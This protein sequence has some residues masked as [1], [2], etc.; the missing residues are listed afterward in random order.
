M[1][2]AAVV[3]GLVLVV[4][5]GQ[6]YG[7]FAAGAA[8]AR[9]TDA[10]AHH[11]RINLDSTNLDSQHHR[12]RRS[13]P[14][15]VHVNVEF[16]AFDRHFD[17]LLQPT[18]LPFSPR[19]QA[20]LIT[21]HGPE[22]IDFKPSAFY[23]GV[24]RGRSSDESDIRALIVDGVLDGSV[25]VDGET[26]YIEPAHR[27]NVTTHSH[28]VYKMS[29]VAPVPA[30]ACGL[31]D[32]HDH[33]HGQGHGHGHG[34]GAGSMD[35]AA[36]PHEKLV[37]GQKD[38][39]IPTSKYTHE[40]MRVRRAGAGGD[41]LKNTCELALIADH[42]FFA[43]SQGQSSAVTTA[44]A[45]VA[46]LEDVNR[47]YK[48]TDWD[49]VGTGIQLAVAQ[50]TVYDSAVASGNPFP[51]SGS[52][53][54]SAF[55]DQ[56]SAVDW[57]DFCLAHAFTTLDFD[58]G[59]LGLAYVGTICRDSANFGTSS[60]TGQTLRSRNTGITTITNFGSTSPRTQSMLVFAHEL[61]H[62]FGSNHDDSCSSF[63]AS[64]PCDG[65]SCTCSSGT[66]SSP[67]GNFVMFPVSVD[68][69]EASNFVFSPCSQDQIGDTINQGVAFSAGGFCFSNR[70][71]QICGNSI[72][73]GTEECDCGSTDPTEC[74]LADPCCSTDCTLAPGAVCSPKAG[75]C[76]TSG[77][78]ATGWPLA[79]ALSPP[80]NSFLCRA[81]T[82][83]TNAGH[84]VNESSFK[85][86][87]PDKHYPNHEN[88]D[89]AGCLGNSSF[90]SCTQILEENPV[91]PYDYHKTDGTLC[92]SASNVCSL[93]SCSG[94]V[95]SLFTSTDNHSQVPSGG[96]DPSTFDVEECRLTDATGDEDCQIACRWQSGGPCQS[97]FEYAST[98]HGTSLGIVGRLRTPGRSCND[99]TGFCSDTGACATPSTSTPLDELLNVDIDQWVW[100]Y[101]YVM[102]GL[103]IGI[104]LV[105]FCLR[106]SYGR[107]ELTIK[108][109]TASRRFLHTIR[110]SGRKAKTAADRP[111]GRQPQQW[112]KKELKKLA[113]RGHAARA[114]TRAHDPR[115]IVVEL[116]ERRKSSTRN[117]AVLR[118]AA[119]FPTARPNVLRQL[120][121]MSPHEEAAVGRLIMLGYPMR[122]LD[123]YKLLA[124]AHKRKGQRSQQPQKRPPQKK[125]QPGANA[126][127]ASPAPSKAAHSRLLK[128]PQM[129]ALFTK[130][131]EARASEYTGIKA[132]KVVVGS[133][134]MH[135]ARLASF[136]PLR[137]WLVKPVQGEADVIAV[138]FQEC[139]GMPLATIRAELT[140]LI[141]AHRPGFTA[142]S[143]N[144]VGGMVL[145]VFV[146]ETHSRACTDVTEAFHK[147]GE[148]KGSVAARMRLYGHK[149]AFICSYFEGGQNQVNERHQA[150]GATRSQLR[151]GD[152]GTVQQHENVFWF[153]CLNY[154]ISMDAAK[155]KGLIAQKNFR[156]L[157]AADQLRKGQLAKSCFAGYR[158]API[159]FA[160]TYK[161]QINSDNWDTTEAKRSPSYTDRVLYRTRM[162]ATVELQA[163]RR[164]NSLRQSDHRPVALF[165]TL[166]IKT[167]N[168]AKRQAIEAEVLQELSRTQ[169]SVRFKTG[170]PAAARG[171]QGKGGKKGNQV[172]PT[173]LPSAAPKK[174]AL[175][176]SAEP[177]APLRS[178]PRTQIAVN[179]NIRPGA[180]AA[181]ARGGASAAAPNKKKQWAKSQDK[182][183][184]APK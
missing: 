98:P 184:P 48:F 54:S 112:D 5:I 35:G 104:V 174:P 109:R 73:E 23:R 162:D 113:H 142:T 96:Y 130:K 53:D 59:V 86:Q 181:P 37:Y 170:S 41:P 4:I 22:P 97:T 72:V 128:N 173:P 123:D 144:K 95:C 100:D 180:G 21:D 154:R 105:A 138:G 102:W 29:D 117:H 147:I 3:L 79:Q 67:T 176:K 9:L 68:G 64:N 49:G 159:H 118:L 168:T 92:N 101:W 20:T 82:E 42:R 2:W 24:A 36:H 50:L 81:E 91:T 63:C 165:L 152:F 43:S 139:S 107:E 164:C 155:C 119:L 175:K 85:G 40:N 143:C 116:E 89:P 124:Y 141:Q 90:A 149:F 115:K 44:N 39:G 27:Y 87:C 74:A 25:W 169:P 8:K 19:L 16:D 121:G 51:D 47:I 140:Q 163:Y 125:K 31:T 60:F 70:G 132:L 161:Y 148:D 110:R 129:Q 179:T 172:A 28:V 166:K 69:S 156:E 122:L 158:E 58:S 126:Q 84:C 26:Y 71:D 136:A 182:F 15:A 32:D 108:A 145:T 114:G 160:P 177:L 93:G 131:M 137:D 127:H 45:L 78:Q 57:S 153:G 151:F 171:P 135:G 10:I 46:Y 55:L 52:S 56:L 11:H 12:V 178:P 14:G 167:S 6:P 111:V 7:V 34:H 65:V 157:V 1:A 94:T 18:R 99:G 17:L 30:G 83:C 88:Y 13:E 133:W 76:C 146:H 150:Y 183:Y 38:Q 106:W 33:G 134:H 66:I 75:A 80:D 62:N 103:G 61:G 120:V 77:C